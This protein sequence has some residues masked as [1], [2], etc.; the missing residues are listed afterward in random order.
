M[1]VL[2]MRRSRKLPIWRTHKK[3]KKPDS[4]VADP[5]ITVSLRTLGQYLSFLRPDS[6]RITILVVLTV[7]ASLAPLVNPLVFRQIVDHAIPRSDV[8]SLIGLSMVSSG[9]IL[10]SIILNYFKEVIGARVMQYQTQ[11]LRLTLY[12]S[13]TRRPLDS[14]ASVP[15]GEP[16]SLASHGASEAASLATNVGPQF[17][18]VVAMLAGTGAVLFSTG[19]PLWLLL[20]M[21]GIVPFVFLA[22]YVSRHI[23]C[24]MSGSIDAIGAVSTHISEITSPNGALLYRAG[25]AKEYDRRKFVGKLSTYAD[26]MLRQTKWNSSFGAAMGAYGG[27]ALSI[28]FF[29]GGY[30]AIKGDMTPGDVVALATISPMVINPLIQSSGIRADAA[31]SLMAFARIIGTASSEESSGGLQSSRVDP[32][33]IAFDA[34]TGAVVRAK[35]IK[36]KYHR[37]ARGTVI[38]SVHLEIRQGELV[39]MTGQSGAG[40]S[41]LLKVLAGIDTEHEGRVF[42]NGVDVRYLT[43]E[44]RKNHVRYVAQDTL[45]FHDTV[46]ENFLRINPDV[47]E[48][49]MWQVLDEVG[50][51]DTVRSMKDGLRTV[52]GGEQGGLSGGQA[53]RLSIARSIVL[54]PSVLIL[55]EPFAHLD[56]KTGF[57]ILD[58]IRERALTIILVTHQKVYV[59]DFDRHIFLEDGCVKEAVRNDE[60]KSPSW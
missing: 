33:E 3:A 22:Q 45:L 4:G 6:A 54:N 11:R 32:G 41:T 25:V 52:V 39:S 36:K 29:S 44:Q 38:H 21:V 35:D 51:G 49:E 50:L 46:A 56:E 12:N 27:I 19:M 18:Q 37:S 23:E 5:E 14:M 13:Y 26:L 30:L 17:L 16:V 43:D 55:D 31:S 8:T 9:V 10:C 24:L 20:P 59:K 7:L 1:L 2:A 60:N 53:A 58:A 42:Y 15:A 28:L 57:T 40:K 47:T 48:P 34:D